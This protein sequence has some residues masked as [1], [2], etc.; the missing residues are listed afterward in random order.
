MMYQKSLLTSDDAFSVSV[1]DARLPRR[2]VL[3]AAGAGGNPERHQDLLESLAREGSTVVAPHFAR[4]MSPIPTAT[5][6]LTRARRLR[7]A[8]EQVPTSDLPLVGAGHSIGAGLLIALAGGQ[9]WL[10][11]EQS[12]DVARMPLERLALLSPAAGFFQA[13]GALKAVHCPMTVW[14]GSED[15]I[16]QKDQAAFL[17]QTLRDQAPIE[18]RIAE[19]AGH[20]SFMN[21]LPPGVV[22]PMP[23]RD[24]FLLDLAARIAEFLD[25]IR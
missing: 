14:V 4:L 2:V 10:S 16:A 3:F 22:D 9:M 24:A 8:A 23:D 17:Q 21:V 5:E 25:P 11:R 1:I 13:P 7:L 19:G 20:Y 18:V 15:A 12:L 6:L